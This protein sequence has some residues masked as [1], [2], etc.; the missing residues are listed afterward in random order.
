MLC[1]DCRRQVTRGAAFCGSCGGRCGGRRAPLELVLPSGTRV[2]LIG[3]MVIGRAPASTLRLDDPSVSRTHARISAG[4]GDGADRGRG[5]EPRHVRRRRADRAPGG[6]A[7]R[8]ADPRSATRSSASSAGAS[9]PRPGARSSC[10]A[11]RD[12][13]R[14]RRRRGAGG[15]GDA[16]R[17][18]AAGALGLRAQAHG[19][20]RGPA[21]LG[22]AR[23]LAATRTCG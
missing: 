13:G 21:P 17:H 11:G 6:A 1:P 14:L 22:A 9:R 15:A 19:G 8:R 7:R 5:L 20:R 2:P 10:R 18:A 3:D 16:V 4:D 23:P 12:A